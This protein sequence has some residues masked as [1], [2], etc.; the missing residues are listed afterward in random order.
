MKDYLIVAVLFVLGA[1]IAAWD[2]IF[3][4]EDL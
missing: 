1:F 2:Y 4:R 3:H